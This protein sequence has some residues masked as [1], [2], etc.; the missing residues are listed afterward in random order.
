MARSLE[1]RKFFHNHNN[2]VTSLLSEEVLRSMELRWEVEGKVRK[3][4]GLNLEIKAAQEFIDAMNRGLQHIP[5]TP[6]FTFVS[7]ERKPNSPWATGTTLIEAAIIAWIWEE[8]G[9]VQSGYGYV[10]FSNGSESGHHGPNALGR[11]LQYVTTEKQFV[12]TFGIGP[13]E[14]EIWYADKKQSEGLPAQR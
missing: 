11:E 6:V 13:R 5:V 7:V 1:G 12:E 3:D 2:G 14:L 9:Q 4:L 8:G 10:P